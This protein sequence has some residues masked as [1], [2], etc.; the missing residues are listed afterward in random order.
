[1]ASREFVKPIE[2][3]GLRDLQRALKQMDGESQKLLRVVLNSAAETVIGGARRRVPRGPSGNARASLK[4][5]SGQR[6]AI[7]VGG[8]RKAPYY[9]FLEFGNKVRAGHGVGR[10]DSVPRKF[11]PGGR[12]MYP[13]WAANRK[14]IL[15]ALA[16]SIS[17]LAR[18][19]GL[20]VS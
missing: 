19:S 18:N 7:V 20:E 11:V 17:D 14:S 8:G 15:A 9:G 12:Y 13:S 16:D 1:M 6:E 3:Q 5:R 10:G 2:I 4:P